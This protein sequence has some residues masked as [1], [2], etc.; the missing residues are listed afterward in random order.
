MKT[1]LKELFLVN[2]EKYFG[3][4]PL[5]IVFF[6]EEE[7]SGEVPEKP[8]GHQCII[9]PLNKVRKGKVLSFSADVLG[10]GGAGMYCGFQAVRPGLAEFLSTGCERYIDTPEHAEHMIAQVPHFKAPKKYITFKRID[11]LL[12]NEEAEAVV[13]FAHG[14]L[15]SGLFT[16][17]NYN[18]NDVNAVISPFGSG[19]SLII[20]YPLR[21][22]QSD[23][24]RAVL[25]M[26]DVSARLCV[27]P[28]EL[29]FA[30]PL[31]RF[32]GLVQVMDECF[33]ITDDWKKVQKRIQKD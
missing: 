31:K 25:G 26:F 1:E 24:P 13:F 32:E 21:E 16:W 7:A 28:S 5:P 11:Q 27:K 30:I 17:V 3:R 9:C 2:W 33:F 22:N 14:D 8:Q 10:C 23:N 15:L 12:E 4:A 19:C 18:A 20:T 6:F 29:S